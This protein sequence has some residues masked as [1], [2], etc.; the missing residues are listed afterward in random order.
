MQGLPAFVVN[1]TEQ[2]KTGREAQLSNAVAAK[3]V[4][5]VI[6]TVSL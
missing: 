1:T 5:D 3:T 2:R 6:R 4:A